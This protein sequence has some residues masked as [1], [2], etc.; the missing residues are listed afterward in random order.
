MRRYLPVIFVLIA[1]GC[2]VGPVLAQA[3]QFVQFD[4]VASVGGGPTVE[5][6]PSTP[7]LGFL[8]RP[9]GA[10]TLPAVLL[11]TDCR[12]RHAYHEWWARSL[13]ARG[14]VALVVDHY[15]MREQ[16]EHACDPEF[17]ARNRAQ[18]TL[19]VR[20][21]Y[22]YL[23]RLSGVDPARLAVMGWGEAPVPHFVET[24]IAREDAPV[25]G[26]VQIVPSNCDRLQSDVL[27]WLLLGRDI[28]T[29][30]PAL[31]DHILSYEGVGP[32]FDDPQA[33]ARVYADPAT[34]RKRRY[35]RRAHARALTDIVEFL[36]ATMVPEGAVARVVAYPQESPA[37]HL[38]GSW[39][40]DPE[41]PGPDL[42]PVG[43]SL[44]D[45]VFS[46][47]RGGEAEYDLPFPFTRLVRHLE[48]MAGG[49]H[50]ARSP[51]DQALIPLGRSLQREVSAPDYFDSP[52]IVVGVGRVNRRGPLT[53][54]DLANRLFLGY[55]P[56]AQV[57]EVI[58][59][60]AAANR[61]EFQVVSGYAEDQT[62]QVGYASRALCTSC[63]QN[64][65]PIFAEG[66]WDETNSNARMVERMQGLGPDFHGIAVRVDGRGVSR[67]DL[68][69]DQANLLPIVQSL[70]R[71]GCASTLAGHTLR[72]RTG[73][74][75]AMLQYRLSVGAGFDREAEVYRKHFLGVY[76]R[77]WARRWPHGLLISSANLPNREPL[78][79]PVSSAVMIGHDPLRRRAPLTRWSHDSRRD[80]DRMVIYLSEMLPHQHMRDL[81][82]LLRRARRAAHVRDLTA[83]CI[84]TQR[85]ARMDSGTLG[86]ECAP[87][88]QSEQ[89]FGMRGLIRVHP[90]GVA[91]G[92][93]RL[94]GLYD[95]V[96]ERLY[97]DGRVERDGPA[98][99]AVFELERRDGSGVRAITGAAIE[100]LIIEWSAG[101]PAKVA[102]TA[103]LRLVDDFAPVRELL[104]HRLGAR[105]EWNPL[106]K[107][108]FDAREVSSWLLRA[109]GGSSVPE[110]SGQVA[111]PV[112]APRLHGTTG[113]TDDVLNLALVHRG[114]MQTLSRYCGACHSEKMRSPPG[115]LHGSAQE[116]LARVQHC[117]A[118]IL[119][120]LSMWHLPPAE[121]RV[122]P[123]PPT[124]GLH[125]A[126]TDAQRWVQGEELP[127][128]IRYMNDLLGARAGSPAMAMGI[129]PGA[130][131]PPG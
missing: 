50:M 54:F 114:P 35:N 123:M 131:L 107:T 36:R 22:R 33:A 93:I 103:S 76:R 89:P 99:K 29:C 21:A 56:R 24:L 14:F 27:P 124:Q 116:R 69:T 63:H 122:A 68:A 86:L 82:D 119:Q 38:R 42:P 101:A 10:G 25:S 80:L 72:C 8:A 96:Y 97:L 129:R 85:S 43:V 84:I 115:F 59:Y 58:S 34:G 125:R 64:G 117:A 16:R 106:A 19:H 6:Y 46:V 112:P 66:N 73:A 121:R 81:D 49:Q 74:L 126:G 41:E 4:A 94:L 20:G 9:P 62:P 2:L 109:L 98:R 1:A 61:F 88:A 32:G 71:E 15:F 47:R 55:Q 105:S 67:L 17:T 91:R 79:S 113:A 51:L 37:P 100:H 108:F 57:I 104:L 83:Q 5:P 40:I 70:W 90:D 30:S 111:T 48:S 87:A 39:A 53:R 12:G 23:S 31:S 95:G 75:L 3:A 26:A 18:R 11:L 120:R 110:E 78:M 7:V 52:R 102:A 118:R 65:A 44:F 92:E 128:L 77:N 13:S 127:R 130:C 28:A 60:N 45:R